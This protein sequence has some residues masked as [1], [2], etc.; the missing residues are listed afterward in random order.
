[1]ISERSLPHYVR[2]LPCPHCTFAR[3]QLQSKEPLPV[4]RLSFCSSPIFSSEIHR[5]SPAQCPSVILV[6][7]SF[8]FQLVTWTCLRKRFRRTSGMLYVLT[9]QNCTLTSLG[10]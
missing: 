1:M 4:G 10:R 6:C 8:F 7:P 2:S 5:V 3:D 9:S